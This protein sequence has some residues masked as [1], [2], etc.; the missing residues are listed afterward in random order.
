MDTGLVALAY[1]Q[2]AEI[3]WSLEGYPHNVTAYN[4]AKVMINGYI[5][6]RL[7]LRKAAED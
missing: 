5:G 3:D 7:G 2:T 4:I 6:E 1:H